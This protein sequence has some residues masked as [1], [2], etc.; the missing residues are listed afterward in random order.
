MESLLQSALVMV[1]AAEAEKHQ[2]TQKAAAMES[3]ANQLQARLAE[4]GAEYTVGDLQGELLS[5]APSAATDVRI[6]AHMPVVPAN[7]PQGPLV[8]LPGGD[9]ED[10]RATLRSD[11]RTISPSRRP[12][13]ATRPRTTHTASEVRQWGV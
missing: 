6:P 1:K 5:N 8:A 12:P 10:T 3:R 9:A 2:A 13:L 11:K 7:M 4:L